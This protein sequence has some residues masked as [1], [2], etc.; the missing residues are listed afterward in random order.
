MSGFS[1]RPG[2][3]LLNLDPDIYQVLHEGLEVITVIMD[4]LLH[5]WQK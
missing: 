2:A 3:E 5:C 1:F 4:A